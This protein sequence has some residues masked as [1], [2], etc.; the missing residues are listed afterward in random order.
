MVLRVFR[1]E[2]SVNTAAQRSCPQAS[3]RRSCSATPRRHCVSAVSPGR[4]RSRSTRGGQR[5]RSLLLDVLGGRGMLSVKG[6]SGGSAQEEAAANHR[7]GCTSTHSDHIRPINTPAKA[8]QRRLQTA[9]PHELQ[10]PGLR[11]TP[12]SNSR[13]MSMKL[14]SYE[15]PSILGRGYRQGAS[16]QSLRRHGPKSSRHSP[17]GPGLLASLPL[18]AGRW[19]GA[20]PSH[21]S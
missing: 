7:V 5:C 4:S 15:S 19:L 20:D 2:R 21:S 18:V 6:R 17:I 11:G 12:S 9:P 13:R 3:P 8:C 1:S 16:C 14:S 10:N